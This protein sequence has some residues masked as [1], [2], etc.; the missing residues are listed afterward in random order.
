[1]VWEDTVVGTSLRF[2]G[3]FSVLV[4]ISER[5]SVSF[6]LAYASSHSQHTPE[7]PPN[8]RTKTKKI[9]GP[10]APHSVRTVNS[11]PSS[12]SSLQNKQDL[13]L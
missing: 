13:D 11:D 5:L 7:S 10:L 4:R 9:N 2:V 3:A 1:M 6:R 12:S 8:A